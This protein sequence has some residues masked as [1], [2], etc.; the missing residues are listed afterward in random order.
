[1]SAQA[2]LDAIRSEMEQIAQRL[3]NLSIGLTRVVMRDPRARS[4]VSLVSNF[5]MNVQIDLDYLGAM[6]EMVGLARD[7]DAAGSIV[8][9]EMGRAQERMQLEAFERDVRQR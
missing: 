6:L 7:P 1:M 5:I 2:D 8:L 4:R 3:S 9:R